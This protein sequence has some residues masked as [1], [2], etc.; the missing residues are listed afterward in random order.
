MHKGSLGES[1]KKRRPRVS[2]PTLIVTMILSF[3]IGGLITVALLVGRLGN[4]GFSVI[5]A[6]SVVRGNFVG[7]YEWDQVTDQ[8]L[9][10]M[11]YSLGDQWSYYLTE[12][13]YEQV[14]ESRSN[15]YVGIGVTI[16]TEKTDAI[17]VM[18]VK[19]NSPAKE[20]GIRAGDAVVAVGQEPVNEENWR[21]M[22]ESISG[23]AGTYVEL[24]VRDETGAVQTM[25]VLRQEIYESPVDYEMV[26][27][28]HTIGLVRLKNFYS[29]SAKALIEACDEL[30]E[31]GATAIIF[32]VRSNPGGYVTELTKML[33]YLL[34]E[35]VIFQS[36]D[37]KGKETVYTSDAQCLNLPFAVIVN[38]DSYSAAEFLAAQ[39]HESANAVIVG[40]QTSGKG[41]AQQLFP[42]RNGSALGISTSQ[43]VTGAGISLIGTGILP[44]PMVELN[45]DAYI[46]FLR[47]ELG[48]EDDPQLQA[49][50]EA[51]LDEK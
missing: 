45:D 20:A 43:Y 36:H 4:N 1:I 49:A 15:S 17:Y 47:G 51:L 30:A 22:V 9:A 50:L 41:Y 10:S 23:S 8:T 40:E 35:G 33:D 7:D 34:P 31:A 32:D 27:W 13:E 12:S 5:Q 11:V 26:D 44:D 18:S 19:A 24:A 37:I 42:L 28:E 16:S 46:A 38:S 2:L 21:E 6:M 29:G 3:L 48:H 25:E 39:L 14:L